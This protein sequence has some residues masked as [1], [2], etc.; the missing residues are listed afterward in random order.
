MR[1]QGVV[2]PPRALLHG[3]EHA[4]LRHAAVQP[5][6]EQLLLLLL[7]AQLS[8]GCKGKGGIQQ[9]RHFMGNTSGMSTNKKAQATNCF[10]VVSTSRES[11]HENPVSYGHIQ[12]D[13]NREMHS[14]P[15]GKNKL[16]I[17]SD[18]TAENK[19]LMG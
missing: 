7:V 18:T 17:I 16:V 15:R 4:A 13:I 6:P 3:D 10:N 1:D 19:C 14:K 11:G 12:K 2:P 8:G 9:I 5:L